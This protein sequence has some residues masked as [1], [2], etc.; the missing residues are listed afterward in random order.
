MPF[1]VSPGVNVSEIDLTTVVP[2]VSTTEG[3]L[4]GV[5]RWGP[6]GERVLVDSEANLVARFGKP[7]NHN[8]ETF[9]TAA[10]FLSYGNKLYV[11][12]VANTTSNNTATVCRNAIANVANVSNWSSANNTAN[13][14]NALYIIK[15]DDHFTS[16]AEATIEASGD[17]D[18]KYIAKYPG[19]LG[20]SLKISVCDSESAYSNQLFSTLSGNNEVSGA[21]SVATVAVGSSNVLF[22]VLLGS[23]TVAD[24]AAKATVMANLINVGDYLEVGNSTIGLQYMK[25]ISVSAVADANSSGGVTSNTESRFTVTTED[26]YNLSENFS[27]NSVTRKWEY[28]NVVDTAPGTSTYQ[29]NFG[30]AANTAKDEIHFVITDEDGAVSGIPGTVLEVF[31][32]LSRATNAK[33]EDG[34]TNYFKTIIN[35]NS[36]YVWAVKDLTSGISDVATAIANS[37]ATKATTLSF[38]DGTDAADENNVAVGVVLGGYDLYASAE[39]VDVSLLLTGVSRGG[40]NGE[41]IANY[42]IDNIAEK[43][44]DCVVFVS[45]QKADLIGDP[46]DEITNIVTFRNSLR[47]TS[48]AVM[49]SGY[50]YQYD[51]YN[52]L[53]RYVPLNGDIAGLCVRTDDT[54]DPWFS[55][56]GFN[57]GQ[58]KNIVKLA[59]N[60]RQADRDVLYKA[61]VNPVVTFPGQGTV[62]YGDK[63]LL[64]KP[65]AFDRI[66]VRR[67]FIVLEKAIATAAKFTLFEFNDDFTRAQFRNLVEPFLRDV[68]GRRGIYDFQVVCDTTNNTGE[69]I[70]RNEFIGDIYIKPARSINFI[71]LNFVAVRTGVE[72]SEVVGQF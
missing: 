48:Y 42:L 50:K 55:P 40:T 29:S 22:R 1:Q 54:R 14:E 19:V 27:A 25:V 3:A 71:Q 13:S 67:L 69:V 70:D 34:S 11:T 18:V 26:S 2:A 28:W 33:T 17:F 53:Y 52:D 60:P 58:I 21:N 32:G 37:T 23:G 7:T 35:Q 24:T 47:S 5:F 65:S 72:F 63:T 44:K 36:N 62:L 12:R 68:Q 46:G 66:N 59:Y 49:D 9:F 57:R 4:A 45:P 38:I 20:N 39:D 64:A 30:G 51:K 61:G 15:N 8:A 10:N 16:N 56:A 43:R 31:G 41:Q 6:V